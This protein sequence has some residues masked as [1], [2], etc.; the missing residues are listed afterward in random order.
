MSFS[1][2]KK[3]LDGF[4]YDLLAF[5]FSTAYSCRIHLEDICTT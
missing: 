4:P 5:N 2:G 1:M 3:K